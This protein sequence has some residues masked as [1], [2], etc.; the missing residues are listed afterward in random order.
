MRKILPL[1]SALLLALPGGA[2]AQA[3]SSELIEGA[4][5]L[6]GQTVEFRGEAIGD[7]MPRGDHVWLNVSDGQNTLGRRFR[8]SAGSAATTPA[9]TS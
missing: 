7:L 3:S 4:S 1:A 2:Q 8:R 5:R 9:G 6:D